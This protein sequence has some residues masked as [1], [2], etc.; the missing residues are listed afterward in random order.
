MSIKY[1]NQQTDYNFVYPNNDPKQYD[2]EIVH[3]INNN[4][5]SGTC[6]NFTGTSVSSS[7]IN[8]SFDYTWALNNA[9]PFVN[10]NNT[11][12]SILSVH[13]MT[14]DQKY[15]K[16]WRCVNSVFGAT[17]LTTKSGTVSFTITPSQMGESEFINGTY[18]YEVRMI[19]KRSVYP[20]CGTF[21]VTTIVQPT[22]TPTPTPTITPTPSSTPGNT[23]TPTPTVSSS[24]GAGSIYNSG[25]TINVTDTGWI[26][27]TTVSGDTYYQC[28]SLGTTVL[29][30]C[31]VCSSIKEGIPFADLGAWTLVNCGSPCSGV[32]PTP[33]PTQSPASNYGYYI[34]T[35][36]QNYF[37]R[38][39]QLLPYGTFN[40][41]DRVQGSYGYFY[42]ITGFTPS[43]QPTTYYVTA[44]GLFG[45]P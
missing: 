29:P 39:S 8:I 44:T 11:Q 33:T 42:V 34:M 37:T 23:P 30:D 25:V 9:Q 5:V 13:I 1:I 38:Y 18:Y 21:D 17:N 28:T 20:I 16:A 4:S 10:S 22:P 40:S 26:K 6:T 15:Y 24:P 14:A 35:D 32:Y 27:Y 19:G 41:G 2:V 12:I 36:C 45:C 7:S 31:L 3:D 43:Y